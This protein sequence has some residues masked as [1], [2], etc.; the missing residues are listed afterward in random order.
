MVLHKFCKNALIQLGGFKIYADWTSF[1]P[2][3][4]LNI[5]INYVLILCLFFRQ[6]VIFLKKTVRHK[7]KEGFF[8]RF[9]HSNRGK[10][11]LAFPEIKSNWFANSAFT[12]R[13]SIHI[14]VFWRKSSIDYRS[15]AV[16]DHQHDLKITS[17]PTAAMTLLG[18]FF[19]LLSE[20]GRTP[21]LRQKFGNQKPATKA[22][23]AAKL[24]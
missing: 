10:Q 16:K 19:I 21:K 17:L 2:W 22:R 14:L 23:T 6:R 7:K 3:N 20:A 4:N 1:C 11:F 13:D 15:I 5:C 12:Q 18:K 8:H 9:I 24:Q